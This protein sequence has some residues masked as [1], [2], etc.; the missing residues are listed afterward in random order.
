VKNIRFLVNFRKWSNL[1]SKHFVGVFLKRVTAEKVNRLHI[2]ASENRVFE[3]LKNQEAK[4]DCM[5]P[6]VARY[7]LRHTPKW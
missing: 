7:Q 3:R 2:F 5:L 4:A 1:W 6:N